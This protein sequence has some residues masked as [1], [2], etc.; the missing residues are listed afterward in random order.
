MQEAKSAAEILLEVDDEVKRRRELRRPRWMREPK[1]ERH[2]LGP[3]ARKLRRQ[4]NAERR[5]VHAATRGDRRR[6]GRPRGR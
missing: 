4:H 3:E 5:R 1:R 6:H 2:T